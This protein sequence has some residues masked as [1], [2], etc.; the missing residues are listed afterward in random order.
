MTIASGNLPTPLSGLLVATPW[1]TPGQ[2]WVTV[3]AS[4]ATALTTPTRA[5]MVTTAGN[6]GVKLA[7]GTDNNSTLVAV[8]VTGQPIPLAVI[9]LTASNTAT[10]LGIT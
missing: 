9:Q 3:P 5:I 8:T 7:D 2:G 1:L 10:I 4:N 6:L